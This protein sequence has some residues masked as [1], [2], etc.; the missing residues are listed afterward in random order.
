MTLANPIQLINGLIF[1]GFGFT[2]IKTDLDL[3]K[4]VIT[5]LKLSF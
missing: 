3:F 5:D 4:T 1:L 2:V